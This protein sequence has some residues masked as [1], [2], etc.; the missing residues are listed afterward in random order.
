MLTLL[1]IVAALMVSG[2]PAAAF[3][4]SGPCCEGAD[5]CEPEDASHEADGENP[6]GD[7]APECPPFC[8]ACPCGAPAMVATVLLEKE[9]IRDVGPPLGI[10]DASLVPETPPADGVFHPPRLHA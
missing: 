5:P 8:H 4:D 3:P 10:V 7:D 1:L 9:P 6:D 2:L